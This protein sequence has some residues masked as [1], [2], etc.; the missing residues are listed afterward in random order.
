MDSATKK[1]ALDKAEAIEEFV[2]YPDELLDVRMVD[3]YYSSL[4]LDDGDYL[5]TMLRLSRFEYDKYFE[6]LHVPVNKSDWVTHGRAVVLNAFYNIVENSIQFPAG[7]LQGMFFSADRPNYMNFGSIG[8]V[9]GHEITHGFDDKGRM[10][11]KTG[12]MR[13]W[14]RR[15][16]SKRFT[17]RALCMVRQY[18]GF[19]MAGQN[20]N[21]MQTLDEN[22][23]D[24]GGV[25]LAYRAY[26]RWSAACA[27][28][29]EP[30]L[31]G[32]DRY[33]P[34]QMFWISSANVWCS[35]YRPEAIRKF[36]QTNQH[37]PG[38]FRV[39]GSFQNQREFAEDFRCPVGSY[40]NPAKKCK[41]W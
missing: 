15:E 14:W 26:S 12:S 33:T 10:Y 22:I 35:V 7:I 28:G 4:R 24:N 39:I 30:R 25:M 2:A 6:R 20:V 17:E 34:R 8:Y 11:D 36:L 13:N 37:S 40:M 9:I 41:V 19:E 1:Y 5:G 16:T 31:P 32:L 27:G 23:A 18:N 21:G 3:G 38:R 29:P